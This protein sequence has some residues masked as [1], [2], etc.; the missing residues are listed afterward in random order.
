MIIYLVKTKCM[1]IEKKFLKVMRI[2]RVNRER[3]EKVNNFTYL[4]AHFNEGGH[5]NEVT[6]RSGATGREFC[7]LRRGLFDRREVITRNH[8]GH[9]QIDSK[10]PLILF[11][12]VDYQL[13]TQI[14]SWSNQW[15]C[16]TFTKWKRRP[17]KI[18]SETPLFVLR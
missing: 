6:W 12:I 16:A 4:G 8:N 14:H 9:L 10:L 7:L 15:R 11:W 2:L 13:E 3:L 5:V 17:N 18:G 1:R